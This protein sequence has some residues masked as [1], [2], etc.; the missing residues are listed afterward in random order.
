[1]LFINFGR[2]DIPAEPQ[3]NRVDIPLVLAEG[4]GGADLIDTACQAVTTAWSTCQQHHERLAT[5]CIGGPD[6]PALAVAL[7]AV[8]GGFKGYPASLCFPRRREGIDDELYYDLDDPVWIDDRNSAGIRTRE[9]V[10]GT[11]PDLS[12]LPLPPKSEA[13]AFLSLVEPD[14]PAVGRSVMRVDMPM[15]IATRAASEM[16]VE[17]DDAHGW[18]VLA[19]TTPYYHRDDVLKTFEARKV[20][21]GLPQ[22]AGLAVTA[23]ATFEHFYYNDTPLFAWIVGKDTDRRFDLAKLL[24][25][26]VAQQRGEE[27]RDQAAAG[28]KP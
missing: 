8:L 16:P 14:I 1:M 7:A 17:S 26:T 6:N 5:A 19:A 23:A 4:Y 27:L 12:P 21:V 22:H 18:A 15:P 10:R 11:N 20:I 13:T 2:P 25:V 28:A 3:A 24:D 9:G